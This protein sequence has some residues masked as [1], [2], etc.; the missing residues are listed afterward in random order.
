MGVFSQFKRR[1]I[2]RCRWQCGL[3]LRSTAARLLRSRVRI[4]LGGACVCFVTQVEAS[5]T[6]RSL[7]QGSPTE[8]C[9]FVRACSCLVCDQVQK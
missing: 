2:G 8:C 5:A 7:V 3:R 9:V 1:G 6:G 4:A